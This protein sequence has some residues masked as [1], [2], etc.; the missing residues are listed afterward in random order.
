MV[1]RFGVNNWGL[2]LYENIKSKLDF[3]YQEVHSNNG[4]KKYE[5]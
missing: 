5:K 3:A 4:L 2:D 1:F